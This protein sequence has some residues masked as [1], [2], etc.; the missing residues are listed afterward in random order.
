MTGVDGEALF[1]W[2]D[3]LKHSPGDVLNVTLEIENNG[4]YAAEGFNVSFYDG[5]PDSGGTLINS[6]LVSSLQSDAGDLD[7]AP[8]GDLILNVS[9]IQM[10]SP[11]GSW[12]CC[13]PNPDQ[14]WTCTTGECN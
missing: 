14:T 10:R 7:I 9:E 1:D 13:H 8:Q 6:Q 12:S 4:G 11:D 2:D 3:C 5:N